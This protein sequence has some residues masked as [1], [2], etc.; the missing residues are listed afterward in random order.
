MAG[1]A[2]HAYGAPGGKQLLFNRAR[3]GQTTFR[4]ADHP[5]HLHKPSVD[6]LFEAATQAYRGNVL[7][8]VMTGMGH[9]GREGA[10]TLRA[11]GGRIIAQDESSSVVYGMPRAIAEAGLAD[12][13][14]GLDNIGTT[15]VRS[16][17]RA[18]T[19]VPHAF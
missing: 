4:V 3:P 1:E 6:V 7:G 13:V 19:S 9:D 8:V 16:V 5:E 15:I 17:T 14:V 18:A 11:R 10:R 12:A 2:G